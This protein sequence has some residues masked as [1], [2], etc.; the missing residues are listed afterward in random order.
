MDLVNDGIFQPVTVFL[1][2]DDVMAS[3]PQEQKNF[4]FHQDNRAQLLEYLKYHILQSQRVRRAQLVFPEKCVPFFY[5]L[6]TS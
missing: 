5:L 3:L 1:P 6:S 4:L 2:S